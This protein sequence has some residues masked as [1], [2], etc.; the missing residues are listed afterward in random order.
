M[1]K[2]SPENFETLLGR[3][4]EEFKSKREDLL[5]EI[6]QLHNSGQIAIIVIPKCIQIAEN[7]VNSYLNEINPPKSEEGSDN[8]IRVE[9]SDFMAYC[10]VFTLTVPALGPK[11][12]EFEKVFLPMPGR[13]PTAE[14]PRSSKSNRRRRSSVG[15]RNASP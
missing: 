3:L 1:N 4:V 2:I 9:F 7:V 11:V 12:R 6:S 15:K 8:Q 13:A 14:P 10:N 5:A